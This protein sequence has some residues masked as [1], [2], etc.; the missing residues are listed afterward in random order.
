MTLRICGL[1]STASSPTAKAH[2][3]PVQL[4]VD[5]VLA[6]PFQSPMSDG[7]E[8]REFRLRPWVPA[9]GTTVYA[10]AEDQ[11]SLPHHALFLMYF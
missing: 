1:V 2:L 6:Q 5:T 10:P 7:R 8:L 11:E 4:R 3:L 9:A